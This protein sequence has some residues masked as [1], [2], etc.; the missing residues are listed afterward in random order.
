M[1]LSIPE[2]SLLPRPAFLFQIELAKHLC[3]QTLLHDADIGDVVRGHCVEADA[4][5]LGVAGGV[6]RL[7][8]AVADRALFAYSV[9]GFS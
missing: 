6:V 8:N 2:D 3:F 5:T 9:L 4:Q 1:F 7:Q